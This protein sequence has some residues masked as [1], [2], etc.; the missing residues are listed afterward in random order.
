MKAST[1]RALRLPVLIL[2]AFGILGVAVFL[3]SDRLGPGNHSPGPQ[4]TFRLDNASGLDVVNANGQHFT[5]DGLYVT[6]DKLDLRYHASG[7]KDMSFVEIA[8]NPLF[9][10]QP[11]TLITVASDGNV[12][13]PYDANVGGQHGM[14]IIHGRIH[15]ALYGKATAP[16]RYLS[17]P[18]RG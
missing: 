13:V 5:I 8:S 11:P 3:I 10:N 14:P 4:N 16:S 7:V 6:G 9:R 15:L 2:L 12:Y 1:L 17:C 18:A